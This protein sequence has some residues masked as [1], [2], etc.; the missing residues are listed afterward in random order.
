MYPTGIDPKV[1]RDGKP[2]DAHPSPV[3]RLF[4]RPAGVDGRGLRGLWAHRIIID[5]AGYVPDAVITDVL[6]PMLTDVGGE[7]TL[8]SSPAGRRNV[9]YQLWA[10]GEARGGD[11]L[12]IAS[13]QCP[14]RDNPHLDAA[15]LTAMRE[16]L[17]EHTYAAEYEAQFVDDFGAVFREEDIT[18]ALADDPRVTWEEGNLKSA[19]QPGRLYSVGVDWGRKLDFTVVCVLDATERPARLV[20]LH[21][22]QGGSWELLAARTAE[23]ASAYAPVQIL[24]DGNSI[25]DPMAESLQQVLRDHTADGERVPQ[26]ERFLFGAESKAKLVDRLTLA[27]SGRRLTYPHHAALLA[28]LRG[29]EYGPVGASGRARM[30]ARGSGHD[31]IV[32]ALALAWYAAPAGA[33]PPP[34]SLLMLGSQ[35]G[36][37]RREA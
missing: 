12:T 34:G 31:D 4:F 32:M 17:G 35:A 26:V 30:A 19:P 28:E 27:L 22:W 16:E 37:A 21:R 1:T 6:L 25:G 36:L 2:G 20:G 18:A 5:E 11:G 23:V 3:A 7:L 14:S 9:F 15:F 8:A 10:R 29:F 33:P 13:F 24:A